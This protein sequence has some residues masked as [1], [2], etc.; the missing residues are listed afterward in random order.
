M[1]TSEKVP[2]DNLTYFFDL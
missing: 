1:Q 2:H